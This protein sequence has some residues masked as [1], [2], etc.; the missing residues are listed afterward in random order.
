MLARKLVIG[1]LCSMFA[2]ATVPASAQPGT[3]TPPVEPV[4]WATLKVGDVVAVGTPTD[5]A[6]FFDAVSVRLPG[7]TVASEGTYLDLQL[8]A[9]C[10]LVVADAG[11]TTTSSTSLLTGEY[12]T[13]SDDPNSS[14]SDGVSTMAT[15]KTVTTEVIHYGTGGK[16]EVL[17][18][19]D[20]TIEFSY[21]GSTATLT[22]DSG[23]CQW[24]SGWK[25]D[26][27]LVEARV[28]SGSYVYRESRG[29]YHYDPLN[30]GADDYHH[31][32]S[33]LTWG[34]AD[35]GHTCDYHVTGELVNGVYMNCIVG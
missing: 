1:L 24:A 19:K 33:A 29:E 10:A 22:S 23:T 16:D 35:G 27:C 25:N 4:A 15:T 17:T 11:Y 9:A 34:Y 31:N 14:T 21:D 5:H 32:L 3:A 30:I 2:I 6:C 13:R 28:T 12:H 26:A 18:V 7:P 20:Q 8:G